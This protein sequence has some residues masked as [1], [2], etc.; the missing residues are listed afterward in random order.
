MEGALQ[1]PIGVVVR[2][3][4]RG[5]AVVAATSADRPF[6]EPIQGGLHNAVGAHF[7]IIMPGWLAPS[8]RM[9]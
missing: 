4:S 2:G 8:I 9:L 5:A 3:V 6:S 1:L 7:S